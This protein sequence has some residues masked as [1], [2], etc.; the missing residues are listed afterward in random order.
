[1]AN[2]TSA[3]SHGFLDQV[4]VHRDHAADMIK[5][6]LQDAQRGNAT[7]YVNGQ[8]I[9]ISVKHLSP[10]LN[11]TVAPIIFPQGPDAIEV[12]R[13]KAPNTFWKPQVSKEIIRT[14]IF[15][16]NKSELIEVAGQM[17]P[18]QYLIQDAID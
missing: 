15:S 14:F 3:Q 16:T 17:E 2:Y 18:V 7:I 10:Y 13:T 1:M 8:Q 6:W 11:N 12:I 9:P 5:E 4:N